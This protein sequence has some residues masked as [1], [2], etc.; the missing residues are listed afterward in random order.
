MRRDRAGRAAIFMLQVYNIRN[1]QIT[2]SAFIGAVGSDWQ[3]SGVGNFSS[4]PGESDLL[5][6]NSVPSRLTWT[7]RR[8]VSP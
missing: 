3:F 7:K 1:N 6:R 2:G 5:L 8:A 4:V